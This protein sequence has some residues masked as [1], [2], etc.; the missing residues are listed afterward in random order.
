MRR[1]LR[2]GARRMYPTHGG[3]RGRSF[4]AHYTG[5][6][7]RFGP[8]DAFLRTYASGVSALWV[9]F[10]TSTQLLEE[11]ERARAEGKG[12]RPSAA[13]LSHLKKRQGLAWQTYDAAVRRLEELCS[14]RVTSPVADAKARILANRIEKPGGSE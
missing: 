11:T 5:L 13:R 6:V 10:Q 3:A 12:R 8:F 9:E 1:A 7:E 14:R 2:C 4:G